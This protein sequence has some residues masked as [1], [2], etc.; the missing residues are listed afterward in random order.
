M[1]I[2]GGQA[3]SASRVAPT[4]G[5]FLSSQDQVISKDVRRHIAWILDQMAGGEHQLLKLQDEGYETDIFCYWLSA[6]GHGGPELDPEL[7]QRLVS[8]RLLVGFDVHCE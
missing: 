5:W 7:M 1:L 6:S 4:G 2:E 8:L 3:V